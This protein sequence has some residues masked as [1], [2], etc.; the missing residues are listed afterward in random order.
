MKDTQEFKKQRRPPIPSERPDGKNCLLHGLALSAVVAT[1][2]TSSLSFSREL[3]LPT[4][5]QSLVELDQS[6]KFV[7]LGLR[8]P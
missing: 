1:L 7:C 8:H 3:L 4:A 2:L 5:A 6:N